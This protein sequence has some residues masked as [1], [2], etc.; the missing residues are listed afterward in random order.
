MSKKI[1]RTLLASTARTTD[2]ASVVQTSEENVCVRIFLNVTTASGSGG[3]VPVIRGYDPA[4]GLP[5]EMTAG[6]PGAITQ[7][8]LYVYEM[9]PEQLPET[10]GRVVERTNDWLPHKWDVL[11]KHCDATSYTYSVGSEEAN[12]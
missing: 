5:F 7:T 6:G 1:T 3:L 11:V 4:S 2:A 12:G 9:R 10:F 8:G